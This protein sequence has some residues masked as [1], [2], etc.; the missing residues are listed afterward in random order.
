MAFCEDGYELYFF[1][2]E[3]VSLVH[4]DFSFP[5]DLCKVDVEQK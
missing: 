2:Q 5:A 3:S 4:S 1:K